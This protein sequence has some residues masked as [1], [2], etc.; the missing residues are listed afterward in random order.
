MFIHAVKTTYCAQCA[1]RLNPAHKRKIADKSK[2]AK[3]RGTTEQYDLYLKRFE[4]NFHA[5]C[6][7]NDPLY[8]TGQSVMD[9]V[10]VVVQLHL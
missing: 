1:A 5:A 2:A 3:R 4:V 9:D 7:C 10:A 8:L 6:D